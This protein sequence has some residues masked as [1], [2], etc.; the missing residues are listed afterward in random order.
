MEAPERF[1]AVYRGLAVTGGQARALRAVTAIVLAAILTGCSESDEDAVNSMLKTAS[2]SAEKPVAESTTA[3]QK[4]AAP[5]R[6]YGSEHVARGGTLFA[7][8]CAECHGK[9]G[10]GASSWRRAGPDGKY[11]PPPLNGTGHA[12]HHPI[13][14]LGAQ[15]KWGAPGGQGNMPSFGDR[16]SDQQIIDVIAWFQ[17]RWTDEIYAQWWELELRSRQ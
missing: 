17:D 5:E 12:W 7:E 2:S 14:V 15:I 6:W 10:E 3:P 11:P 13:Q 16:L 1:D 8:H 9:N 4:S